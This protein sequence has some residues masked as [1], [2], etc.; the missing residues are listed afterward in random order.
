MNTDFQIT[1]EVQQ[2]RWSLRVFALAVLGIC[3]LTFYPFR[4]NPHSHPDMPDPFLLAGWAKASSVKDA[5]LNVLLFVPFGFGLAGLLRKRGVSRIATAAIVFAAGTLASYTVEFTQFFIPDRDSGWE[6]ILTNSSGA[7]VGSLVFLVCGLPLLRL[8]Q[9]CEMAIEKSVTIRNATMI[10]VCY[11]ACWIVLSA[12]LQR[13]TALRDW[14]TSSVLTVGGLAHPWST[15]AWKGKISALEFWDRALPGNTASQI[16]SSSNPPVPSLGII[17]S[18]RLSGAAAFG[19]SDRAS[20][21]LKLQHAHPEQGAPTAEIWDGNSWL[22]TPAAISDVISR[23][24]KSGRFSIHLQ[25][26][27]AQTDDMDASL[28]TIGPPGGVPDVEIRQASEALAFWFHNGLSPEPFDL[29]WSIS[30]GCEPNQP[31]NVLFSYD[32]SRLWAYMDGKLL[33]EGYRLGPATALARIVRHPKPMELQGYRY[34]YYGI[35]FFP[36]GCLLGFAWRKSR[37]MPCLL[38]LILLGIIV[39]SALLE[40]AL[41]AVGSQPFSIGNLWLGVIMSLIGFIWIDLEGRA[42]TVRAQAAVELNAR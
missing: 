6:D 7:F 35:V 31:R 40:A 16:T 19:D 2:H 36:A 1:S 30:R 13:T 10:L 18:Y 33:Y 9:I 26:T 4:I 29:E 24:Q 38:A 41:V 3:L 5:F 32:G 23:V 27:P 37:G 20:P 8:V 15:Y 12:R 42:I 17:A 34:T 25:F 28:L 39:P 21:S 14:D 11:F 22:A